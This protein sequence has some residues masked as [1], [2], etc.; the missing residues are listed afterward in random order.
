MELRTRA[1]GDWIVLTPTETRIDAYVADDLKKAIGKAVAGGKRDIIL[2]LSNV[3]FL[4]SSG[5][6]V[7][8]FCRQMVGEE[9]RFAISGVV[10][11]VT[12]LLKLTHLD[13]VFCL[14]ASP[15]DLLEQVS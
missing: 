12:A 10:K 3:H 8:V 1:L 5:L 9:G 14:A 4:D 13:K 11:D 7:L 2:D 15:E 6:G